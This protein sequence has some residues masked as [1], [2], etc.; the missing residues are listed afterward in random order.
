MWFGDKNTKLFHMQTI[1]GRKGIRYIGYFLKMGPWS[2]NQNSLKEEAVRFYKG[3]FFCD[4]NAT[5]YFLRL[6]NL[7]SLSEGGREELIAPFTKWEV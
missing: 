3:L 7:L 1:V 6:Q 5:P 4:S 2:C